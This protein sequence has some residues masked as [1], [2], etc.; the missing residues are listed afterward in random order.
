VYSDD[1]LNSTRSGIWTTA[2][3]PVI[4]HPILVSE[5]YK[6]YLIHIGIWHKRKPEHTLSAGRNFT[7]F[8]SFY[9][10]DFDAPTPQHC[11]IVV[12]KL[13]EIKEEVLFIIKTQVYIGT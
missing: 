1:I 6:P 12:V 2:V 13:T 11:L 3:F 10:Y 4:C 7:D 8:S 5:V 9:T